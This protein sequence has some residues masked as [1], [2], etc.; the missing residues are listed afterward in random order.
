MLAQTLSLTLLVLCS[1]PTLVAADTPIKSSDGASRSNFVEVQNAVIPLYLDS[2]PE[3]V[4]LLRATRIHEGLQ[5]RG[6]FRIG[7][8]PTLV[9][10]DLKIE[11]KDA[12][13]LSK[14]WAT[15]HLALRF[16]SK[17]EMP[18]EASNLIIQVRNKSEP[19]LRAGR[20]VFQSGNSLLLTDVSLRAP[21][22]TV[23]HVTSGSLNLTGEH[24]GEF[25]ETRTSPSFDV[26]AG[27]AQD[28]NASNFAK[29]SSHDSPAAQP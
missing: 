23:R 25:F 14:A 4:A 18:I 26:C 17:R 22:G 20:A 7:V 9:V 19:R 21:D 29:E 15:V 6:F 2:K 24:A 13:R 3:P 10:E 11:V 27:D 12:Q 5:R 1:A 8:L 16:G 28:V